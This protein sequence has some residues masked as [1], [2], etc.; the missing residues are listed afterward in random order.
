M[1]Q[2][3]RE[4]EVAAICCKCGDTI[5]SGDLAYIIGED[6]MCL[7]CIAECAVIV[8]PEKIYEN[9]SSDDAC[10]ECAEWDKPFGAQI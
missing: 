4:R 9:I 1:L 10:G 2:P 7:Q 6:V 8:S 5:F 3:F